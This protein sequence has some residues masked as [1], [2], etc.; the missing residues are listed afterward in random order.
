M[1]IFPG[2]TEISSKNSMVLGVFLVSDTTA[3]F[4]VFKGKDKF[5]RVLQLAN[6]ISNP[7]K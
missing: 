7:N 4:P 1:V 6:K 2:V 5:L 3:C